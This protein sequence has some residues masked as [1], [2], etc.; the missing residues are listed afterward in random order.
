MLM[1]FREYRDPG[2]GRHIECLWE[3]EAGPS[4]PEGHLHA[5]PPD[6]CVSVLCSLRGGP[7]LAVGPRLSAGRTPVGP[8]D[9][10]VGARLKPGRSHAVVGKYGSEL[11]D[12]AGPLSL[13]SPELARELTDA[14]CD[15]SDAEAARSAIR[16]VLSEADLADGDP[17]VDAGVTWAL[18]GTGQARTSAVAAARGVSERQLQRSFKKYVGTTLKEYARICRFRAAAIDVVVD[19]ADQW[20]EV[21]LRRGF[22]DQ[23]HLVREF[24][25]VMG[26]TPSEF[27]S[28]F[29]P[30]IEHIDVR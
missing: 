1:R 28:R 22:A 24:V 8:G 13:V 14:L 20:G 25:R 12:F 2:L 29:A 10:F 5:V 26:M 27:K 21:A 17:H 30:E 11:R 15:R 7:V 9:W 19:P 18:D 3:F 4:V 6:G 16:R 23:A